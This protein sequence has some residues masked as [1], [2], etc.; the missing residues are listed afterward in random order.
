MEPRKTASM[1]CGIAA[2]CAL[3]LTAPAYAQT[4][5][6]AAQP[7]RA[8]GASGSQQPRL[9]PGM[10]RFTDELLFGDIWLRAELSPRD[11]SLVVISALIATGKVAQLPG[12]L[13]RALGNGVT[14]R[15]ASGVLTHLA[16]YAGWPSAVSALD[17]YDEVYKSRNVDTAVLRVPAAAL[18][19]PASELA[20]AEA[21]VA[22]FGKIAPKFTDLT[23][24]VVFGDLWRQ[25]DLSVRDRSLVTIAALAAMGDDDQL[26]PYLRRGIEAG[27]TREQMVEALTHLAFYAGFSK[28][29]KAMTVVSRT[30]A[31]ADAR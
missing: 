29:N 5:P 23:N 31:P 7:V 10:A 11:R 2:G 12:H 17:V 15:E 3:A 22:Q 24:Q 18:A 27:L 20:R 13:G 16:I 21:T 1:M 6:A 25:P 8:G 14:P 19:A 30:L 9:A 26:E 4:P 28:A